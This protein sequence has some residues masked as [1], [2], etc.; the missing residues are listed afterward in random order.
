MIPRNVLPNTNIYSGQR[1]M[2]PLWRGHNAQISKTFDIITTSTALCPIP[3]NMLESSRELKSHFMR[4]GGFR[5]VTGYF[6]S[7][8]KVWESAGTCYPILTWYIKAR[9]IFVKRFTTGLKSN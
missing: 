8:G 7:V 4:F 6:T 5:Q 2:V 3:R 9:H 1:Q